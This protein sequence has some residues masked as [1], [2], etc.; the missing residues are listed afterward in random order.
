M[1]LLFLTIT[2]LCCC[3]SG[4]AMTNAYPVACSAFSIYGD[5]AR[6]V[7]SNAELQLRV[8]SVAGGKPSLFTAPAPEDTSKNPLNCNVQFDKSGKVIAFGIRH[9]ND[10]SPLRVL[11][12]SLGA[13]KFSSDFRVEP[14]LSNDTFS[15]FGGFHKDEPVV[16]TISASD[17]HKEQR[18]FS[19]SLYD[20][21]GMLKRPPS[22]FS[23]PYSLASAW[24]VD[25]AHDR[26]WIIRRNSPCSFVFHSFDGNS[27][28]EI[29]A[30]DEHAKTI[31]DASNTAIAY[32]DESTIIGATTHSEDSVATIDARSGKTSEIDLPIQRKPNWTQVSRAVL[33]PDGQVFAVIRMVLSLSALGTSEKF[34]GYEVDFVQVAP[35][36]LLGKSILGPTVAEESISIDHRDGFIVVQ[37]FDLK[38]NQWDTV[39]MKSDD[40]GA[41]INSSSSSSSRSALST[42][43]HAP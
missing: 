41:S 6:A 13:M 16:A 42:H 9:V 18:D 38:R 22:Q 24:S 23:V 27:D 36:R 5:S 11:V 43:G 14:R 15:Y 29:A 20:S 10:T 4:D 8:R 37:S 3:A 40:I 32:P 28:G 26:L 12:A 17:A 39:R 30:A 1:K 33:A 19:I 35:L 2:T 7:I 31:C 25:A 34:H 21:A